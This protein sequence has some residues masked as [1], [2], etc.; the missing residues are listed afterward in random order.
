MS[1]LTRLFIIAA[2]IFQGAAGAPWDVSVR[3]S[4]HNTRSIGPRGIQFQSYHPQPIFE[5]YGVKGVEKPLSRRGSNETLEEIAQTFL[6][7]KLRISPNN[8]THKSGHSSNGIHHQYFR[9]AINGI[10]VAN[11]VANVALKGERV[12]SFGASFVKPKSIASAAPTI[13]KDNAIVIAESATGGNYTQRPIVVELQYFAE[14]S[15]HVLL[16]YIIQVQN[17][18]EG[19]W[20]QVAVD[21]ASGDVVDV[22][23]FVADASYRVI[24]ITS[25]DP[26][27]GF[28]TVTDPYDLVASPNGWHKYS[29]TETTSTSGNNVIA[30]KLDSTTGTTPQSSPV[31]NYIYTFNSQSPVADA[32]NSSTVNAFYI[33]NMMHD[34]LYH[35]GFTETAYNFQQDNNGKGGGDKDPVFISVQDSSRTNNANFVTLPDGQPGQMNM[36]IWTQTTPPRDGA[37]ENDIVVHEYTHGLTNRLTGG[38]TATCLQSIEAQGLGEGWSDAVADWVRQS[39]G[40]DA[41]EDFTMGTYVN[42]RN[43]RDYPYSTNMIA[44]PLTYGSLRSRIEAHAAGEVWAVMWHEIYASLVEKYGFSSNKRDPS[45]GAGNIVALNLL[46]DALQ[47]QPCNPTVVA[48]RDAIIQADASRY[49]GVNKCLLSAQWSA[50]VKRG[51]G[52]RATTDKFDD[53]TLPDGC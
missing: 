8:L 50:F 26:T 32:K 18:Q 13:S 36:Y 17:K 11:A 45:S 53:F 41:A 47:F 46:I 43:I 42:G 7:D 19:E 30:Y 21:A 44:N 6:E 14:D 3:R 27:D 35:Y 20:Y 28:T 1:L 51:L 37:L 52:F 48:A 9:Q 2:T 25:L 10:P 40:G 38:G 24:S 4:T 12:V 16:V 5:T 29:L 39:S 23:S 49:G 22:I 33:G 34:L 15:D 31:N